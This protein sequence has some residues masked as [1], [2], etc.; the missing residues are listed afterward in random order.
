MFDFD[1][2]E[3]VEEPIEDEDSKDSDITGSKQEES[4]K[5]SLDEKLDDNGKL[6]T[7]AGT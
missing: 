3:H 4:D 6:C 7:G 1:V 2:N 5:I